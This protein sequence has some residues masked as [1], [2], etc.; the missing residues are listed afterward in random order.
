[1]YIVEDKKRRKNVSVKIETVTTWHIMEAEK[2]AVSSG[3]KMSCLQSSASPKT[4]FAQ[5]QSMYTVTKIQSVTKMLVRQQ[6]TNLTVNI[7]CRL[8]GSCA[9]RKLQYC[10]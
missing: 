9:L 8:Q 6:V 4:C 10:Q 3:N 7:P 1:M 5:T 2:E